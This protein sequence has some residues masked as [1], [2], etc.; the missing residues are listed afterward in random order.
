MHVTFQDGSLHAETTDT[1]LLHGGGLFP[2]AVMSSRCVESGNAAV[3]SL[4]MH[5]AFS[6]ARTDTLSF[7]FMVTMI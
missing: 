5:G 6:D 4:D 2:S 1:D 3:S 7:P